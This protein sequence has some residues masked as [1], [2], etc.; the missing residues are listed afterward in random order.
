MIIRSA[1]VVL[2]AA[3]IL[4]SV[5]AV[6]PAKAESSKIAL[7]ASQKASAFQPSEFSSRRRHLRQFGHL[8]HHRWTYAK[9]RPYYSHIRYRPYY[10]NYY[11]SYYRPY[12]TFGFYRP[13]HRPYYR[14]SYGSYYRPAYYRPAYSYYRPYSYGWPYSN[15]YYGPRTYI[16]VG[17][18][19]FGFGGLF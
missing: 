15:S 2:S 13:W 17:F 3:V 19:P 12:R 8:R 9:Y 10:R 4:W 11:G 1:S 7:Q 6:A 18:G 14:S 16:S 5:S